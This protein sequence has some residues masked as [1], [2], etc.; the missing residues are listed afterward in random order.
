MFSRLSARRKNA[1]KKT[2]EIFYG[3]RLMNQ[4]RAQIYN[5]TVIF[6]AYETTQEYKT[7]WAGHL[8]RPLNIDLNS[9]CW[10]KWIWYGHHISTEQQQRESRLHA[11]SQ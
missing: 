10:D 7:A 11:V 3:Q 4:F 9:I 6:D 8:R 1:L 5:T 2:Y